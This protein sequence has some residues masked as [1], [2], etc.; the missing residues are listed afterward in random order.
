MRG[1][2]GIRF[3]M[4]RPGSV[5]V[6]FWLV[7]SVFVTAQ[8]RGVAPTPPMGWNSWDAYGLTIDESDFRANVEVLAGLKQYGWEYAVID[9]GWYMQDPFAKDVETR[10]YLFDGNGIL[11]PT[12]TRF[13]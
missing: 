12:A 5:C 1:P 11:I 2:C 9:E 6:V 3:L 13:P 7:A 8:D 4:S 10:K